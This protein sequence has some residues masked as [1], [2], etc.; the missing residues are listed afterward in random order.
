MIKRFSMIRSFVWLMALLL[1]FSGCGLKEQEKKLNERAKSLDEKEQILLRWENELELREADLSKREKILDSTSHVHDT[2]GVYNPDLIG[3]WQVKMLATETTC[4]GSVIGDSKT[5]QWEIVYQNNKYIA[6]AMYGK[7]LVRVYSGIYKDDVL[8][9][10]S[11]PSGA[12]AFIKVTLR[13]VKAN[14]MEGE[15]EISQQGNCRILY[16]LAV[17]KLP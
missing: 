16:S 3:R 9:L 2:I 11:Q 5:E 4:E 13:L 10:T 12:D 6:N 1:L 14:R 15:R 8:L 17:D 7:N